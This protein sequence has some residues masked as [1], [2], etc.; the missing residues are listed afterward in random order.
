MEKTNEVVERYLL[1]VRKEIRNL[2]PCEDFIN[3]LRNEL[4]DYLDI[5]SKI[6]IE[7]LIKEFGTPEVI[8]KEFLESKN[9]LQPQKISKLKRVRN[10]I[11]IFLIGSLCIAGYL[12]LDNYNNRQVMGTDVITIEE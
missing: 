12:I 8:A 5:S 2:V 6:T 3:S 11:I 4:L 1:L 10:T 9:I 7:D